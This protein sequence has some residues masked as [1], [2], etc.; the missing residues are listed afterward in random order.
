MGEI[1]DPL[2]R[3]ERMLRPAGAGIFTVST[4]T[5]EQLKIQRAIYGA[6]RDDEIRARWVATLARAKTAKLILLAVPSDVTLTAVG[7]CYAGWLR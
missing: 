2:A 4:G 5:K 3:L 1:V 6:A 7:L